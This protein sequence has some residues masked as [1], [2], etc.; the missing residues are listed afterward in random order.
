MAES[1]EIPCLN[2]SFQLGML[3]DC[4]TNQLVEGKLLWEE[5]SIKQA[6]ERMPQMNRVECKV[7]RENTISAN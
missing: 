5:N 6:T 7:L 4:R 3:Y 1:L 2:P